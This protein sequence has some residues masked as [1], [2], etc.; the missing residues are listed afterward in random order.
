MTKNY[1]ECYEYLSTQF[2]EVSG[3]EFYKE[4]FPDNEVSGVKYQDFSHPSAIY[5]YRD[6]DQRVRRRKMYC[7]TWEQDY[8]KFVERN[9]FTLCSGLVY[10]R[11]RNRLENAQRMNALIF[12]LDGVGLRELRNLF[13]RFGGDP[14][15]VRRLP[16]PT[17]LVLSGTGLHIYYVFQQPIDLYPNIKIQMK[18][19]KYDL[20]FRMW[21]YKGT[22]QMEAIQYQ[23]INQTFRMVGSINEK[24]DTPLVAFRIGKQVTLEYLNA[25]AKP[26]NRVDLNR[27]F[28]PSKMTRDE[29]KEA[30]PEWYERVVVNGDKRRKQWDIAGK[31]HGDDPHALYHWWL[32]R[33]GE[34]KGGHRYFFLMCMAIY[35]YKCG[36]SKKQLRQDMQEAFEDLQ[37]VKHENVLTEDDVKSALEAYDKEYFNF[38]I[39]DIEVLTDVRIERNKRNGRKQRIH[40]Q[41]A[42]AIQEINDKANGT[43]WRD[44]NGRPIGSGTA[45][46]AV[47]EWQR[48]HPEGSKSQCRL[49]TG[50]SYPTIRKWWQ[51]GEEKL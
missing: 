26:E 10:R 19:L 36:V 23:S 16:M 33:I 4:I 12:D 29:A 20:T 25:Y 14:V 27:P 41:G 37:M 38:T 17:F 13:L 51:T 44:G 31:V 3:C 35:A 5:L 7:D 30:Y 39:A 1:Q 47:C 9:R 46:E 21:E 43:N 32:R 18:S 11:N 2:P 34:I 6:E 15:R 24:Y 45:Q 42:R 48:R 28:K 50:L 40:L 8:T 49:E 22:S